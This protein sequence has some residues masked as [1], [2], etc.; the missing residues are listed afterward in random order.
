MSLN[1]TKPEVSSLAVSVVLV[2]AGSVVLVLVV[3]VVLV[4]VVLALDS[5]S[6]VPGEV[7]TPASS[8]AA[9][10]L[11]QASAKVSETMAL[12]GKLDTNPLITN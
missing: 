4:L 10:T 12:R 2:L 6:S 9:G 7:V 11:V 3:S 8:S 5:P 1:G